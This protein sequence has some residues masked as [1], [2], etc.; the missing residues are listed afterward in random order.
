MRTSLQTAGISVAITFLARAC[1][2]FGLVVFLGQPAWHSMLV[3]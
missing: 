2:V 3:N 1:A